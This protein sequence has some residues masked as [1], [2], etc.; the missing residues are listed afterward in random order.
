MLSVFITNLEDLEHYY[1]SVTCLMS[2]AL[3]LQPIFLII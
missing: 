3:L 2:L 1:P